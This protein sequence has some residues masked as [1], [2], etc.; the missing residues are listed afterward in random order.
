[1]VMIYCVYGLCIIIF[2]DDYELV[3]VYVFGDG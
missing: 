2:M 1:M 3:Y